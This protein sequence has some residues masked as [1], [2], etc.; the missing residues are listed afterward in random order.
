[1]NWDPQQYQ[2]YTSERSRPFFD[3]L[4]QIQADSPAKVLDVGCGTGELT[5]T[6][7]QRWPDAE[8]LG[9]DSSPAM[10]EA[11]SAVS[12]VRLQQGTAQDC[13]ATGVDVLI[14][15]A[16]LQWVPGHE[17]LL[18][19]WSGQLNSDGWLAF[20]VPAN[21]GSPSHVLM[22]ELA[23]AARW[24]PQLGDV[25]RHAD[26]VSTPVRYLELLAGA[27]MQVNVWQTEYL[28]VLTGADPV[29]E[30]VRGTGLRPV[31]AVLNDAEGA[32][33]VA[34]YGRQLRAAYPATENG[35]VFGFTRT[36]V[37]AHKRD[38]SHDRPT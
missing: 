28:H 13:H 29:L 21:F 32:E 6:L 23:Q 31:L 4:G 11:A 24:A 35:T 27:D 16:T 34:E 22:R 15:N 33:F 25:L 12:G 37:V 18:A 17:A 5:A 36:F 30:W 14:S 20:Q 19:R 7:A 2:R 26:A 10:L 8:V 9:I 38:G 1:M 3:L